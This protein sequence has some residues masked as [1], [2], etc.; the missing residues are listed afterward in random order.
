[1]MAEPIMHARQNCHGQWEARDEVTGEWREATPTE[2]LVSFG[3]LAGG[4]H[5]QITRLFGL[6]RGLASDIDEVRLVTLAIPLLSFFDVAR[7]DGVNSYRKGKN[8]ALEEL[9]KLHDHLF[10]VGTQL[11]ELSTEASMALFAELGREG[12]EKIEHALDTLTRASGNA[13][14]EI[15]KAPYTPAKEGR[16]KKDAPALVADIAVRIYED[17][18]ARRATIPTRDNKAYG[19]FLAFLTQLFL[20]LGIN[21][22]PEAA[23]RA[24]LRRKGSQDRD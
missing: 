3:H 9:R 1:M 20:V 22:S 11:R 16:P 21:G 7:T 5:D 17:L 8:N 15:R 24:A 23:G 14:F 10:S 4:N 6:M 18:S 19:P 2:I 12:K 13:Q